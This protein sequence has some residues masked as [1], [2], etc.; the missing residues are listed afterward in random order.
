MND[1]KLFK[2]KNCSKFLSVKSRLLVSECYCIWVT[3]WARRFLVKSEKEFKDRHR[4]DLSRS[5]FINAMCT[6]GRLRNV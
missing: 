3:G 6:A 1:V 4:G 2:G 5:R